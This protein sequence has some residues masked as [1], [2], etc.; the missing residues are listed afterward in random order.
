MLGWAGVAALGAFVGRD[1]VGVPGDRSAASVC[2]SLL[3]M[4]GNDAWVNAWEASELAKGM[5]QLLSW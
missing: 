4:L 5:H 3:T 1:E 2:R